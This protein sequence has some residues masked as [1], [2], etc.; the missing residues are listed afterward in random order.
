MG[1]PPCLDLLE[2]EAIV[3]M[4]VHSQGDALWL[5]VVALRQK[6]DEERNEVS[7]GVRQRDP[8][9][10]LRALRPEEHAASEVESSWM[11]REFTPALLIVESNRARSCALLAGPLSRLLIAGLR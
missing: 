6:P 3:E 8:V 10:V 7:V 4:T 11:P 5:D 1:Q 9:A 2:L